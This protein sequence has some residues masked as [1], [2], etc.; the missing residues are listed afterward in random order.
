[1]RKTIMLGTLIVLFGAGA[2]AQAKDV[3]ATEPTDAVETAKPD[4]PAVRSEETAPK[5]RAASHEERREG[6]RKHHD[7]ARNDQPKHDRRH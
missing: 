2:L 1:M 7:D 3:T 4:A 5:R 6:Q